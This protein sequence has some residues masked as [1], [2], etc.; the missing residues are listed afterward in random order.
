MPWVANDPGG[1]M[2]GWEKL[3]RGGGTKIMKGPVSHRKL[4]P[5]YDNERGKKGKEYGQ[6]PSGKG[7]KGA[8]SK[9]T[10]TS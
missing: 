8:R 9:Y 10:P 7:K 2:P 4:R 6:Q 3:W 1:D 5:W